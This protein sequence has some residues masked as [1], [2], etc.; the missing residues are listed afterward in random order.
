VGVSLEKSPIRR[1]RSRPEWRPASGNVR[2]KCCSASAMASCSWGHAPLINLNIGFQLHSAE[3]FVRR[4][5]VAG[6]N[7]CH[8]AGSTACGTVGVRPS[9]AAA[10]SSAQ[11]HWGPDWM[12]SECCCRQWPA[13]G[14]SAETGRLG[15][16]DDPLRA[17]WPRAGRV[18]RD[19]HEAWQFCH[20]H[21]EKPGRASG[22]ARRLVTS[23][24]P[25]IAARGSETGRS[26]T[27]LPRL[28]DRRP[29]L[30]WL[31]SRRSGSPSNLLH[32][33]R[34]RQGKPYCFGGRRI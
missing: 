24:R 5:T 23:S 13:V 32:G 33:S 4:L 25:W 1:R 16:R 11:A 3:P 18:G 8:M 17:S 21:P 7:Q 12:M 26:E 29:V 2:P 19:A 30:V 28:P 31:A 9:L 14:S 20:L 22:H 15:K 10:L 34:F 6:C 27:P